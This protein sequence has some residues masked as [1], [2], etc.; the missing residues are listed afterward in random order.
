MCRKYLSELVCGERCKVAAL[1]CG[2]AI[3]RRF[4]D[5]GII[6]GVTV[7]CV[8]VSP[9]GDP[10]AYLVRGKTVAIRKKEARGIAVFID[11]SF[12]KG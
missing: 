6:R 4:S 11:T 10:V 8:G 2:G 1:E 7:E 9:L 3:R 12:A 5:L